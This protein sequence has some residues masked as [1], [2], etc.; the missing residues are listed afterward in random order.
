[1]HVCTWV[2]LLNYSQAA[3]TSVSA[4]LLYDTNILVT[5]MMVGVVL[6]VQRGRDKDREV[7]GSPAY[8]R[9][10]HH[11]RGKDWRSGGPGGYYERSFQQFIS[12]SPQRGDSW[13]PGQRRDNREWSRNATETQKWSVSPEDNYRGEHVLLFCQS[14]DFINAH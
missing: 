7:G 1:M 10:P 9:R 6:F 13:S 4:W 8:G 5:I 3:Q 2:W 12:R 14:R 11:S